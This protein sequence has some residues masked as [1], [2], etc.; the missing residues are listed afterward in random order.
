MRVD[1]PARQRARM[2]RLRRT[3]PFVFPGWAPDPAW[4]RAER[5]VRWHYRLRGILGPYFTLRRYVA[6]RSDR[7]RLPKPRRVQSCG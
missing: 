2:E 7:A 5:W 1:N 4:M 6:W 3:R